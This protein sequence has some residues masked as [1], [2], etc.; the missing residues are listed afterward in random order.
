MII[1][2]A[3]YLEHAEKLSSS[4]IMGLE[5]LLTN[6]DDK[7]RDELLH[8]IGIFADAVQIFEE[9]RIKQKCDQ[10]ERYHWT[11]LHQRNTGIYAKIYADKI[12]HDEKGYYNEKINLPTD[13]FFGM[14]LLHD[15][16]KLVMG[17]P[18][19]LDKKLEGEDLEKLKNDHI[20]IGPKYFC[21]NVV[22]GLDYL[23]YWHLLN[24]IRFHHEKKD[25]TGYPMGLKDDMVF[26]YLQ[27]IMLADFLDAATLERSYHKENGFEVKT[28][29]G[30]KDFAKQRNFNKLIDKQIFNCFLNTSVVHP[31]LLDPD[32]LVP[33][34]DFYKSYHPH[35][36]RGDN[37]E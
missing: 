27:I 17:T 22:S 25:G 5:R 7:L 12:S 16:G 24:T 15:I 31:Q 11:I 37:H 35:I 32:I 10:I 21:T 29:E 36:F 34:E 26:G 4:G 19:R 2:P 33:G 8:Y 9:D 14:G 20:E 3:E 28:E 13:L 30:A 1:E 23:Y 6:T 18:K